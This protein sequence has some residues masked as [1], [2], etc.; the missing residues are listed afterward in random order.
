[1]PDLTPGRSKERKDHMKYCFSMGASRFS[2]RR[3][4]VALKSTEGPVI[5]ASSSIFRASAYLALK[6]ELAMSSLKTF[7]LTATS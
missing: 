3:V 6:S 2:S 1:M 7:L 5:T 4:V